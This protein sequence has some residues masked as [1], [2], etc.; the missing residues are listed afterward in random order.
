[1]MSRALPFSP[2]AMEADVVGSGASE[3]GTS[4]TAGV[5]GIPLGVSTIPGSGIFERGGT[6]ANGS[7]ESES[8]RPGCLRDEVS[9]ETNDFGRTPLPGRGRVSRSRPDGY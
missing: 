6:G 1:M 8:N 9:R 2:L 7:S 3:G 5:D 4:A